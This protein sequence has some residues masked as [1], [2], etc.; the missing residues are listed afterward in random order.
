MPIEG[1]PTAKREMKNA[2]AF[3]KKI[4][5]L[6]EYLRSQLIW[7]RA[8]QEE[9][10]NAR[11]HPAIE[12]KIGDKVMLNRRFIETMRP[13]K[14]L[15]WK[16]LGP[17]SIKKVI[18]NTAYQLDLPDSMSEI[19]PVF[20]PWLL[21]LNESNPLPG[22]HDPDPG[23]I[24]IAHEPEW[25]VEEILDS[26]L[27]RRKLDPITREK[28]LL[29]YRI[30]FTGWDTYNQTPK[31]ENFDKLENA[32]DAVADFHHRYPDKPGPHSTYQRPADWEPPNNN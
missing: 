10:A 7:S 1:T 31:W 3:V 12:L 17:Y 5:D 27:Y 25:E 30:R 6:Q 11:R 2:D 23:P 13:N 22:Q 14:S 24:V 16:N 21:H 18:N 29:Q 28:E 4:Q 19:Y 9:Q 20:H 8:K 15:N 26:R 32:R